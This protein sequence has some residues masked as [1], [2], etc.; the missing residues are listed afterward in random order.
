M[1]NILS[2]PREPHLPPE[3]RTRGVADI[4][5]MRSIVGFLG[6]WVECNA[7]CRR[8]KRCASP[9]VECFDRNIDEIAA[10]LEA[11]ACWRRLDGPRGPEEEA[12]P[13]GVLI[14]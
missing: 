8:H 9:T 3:M 2:L 4:T 13:V 12:R 6:G 1:P 14:D 10:T 11:L 7:R 5:I